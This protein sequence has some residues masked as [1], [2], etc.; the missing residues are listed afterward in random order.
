[1]SESGNLK[2]RIITILII[3]LIFNIPSLAKYSGGTGEL[4][5]PYQIAEPNDWIELMNTSVDWD[6]NFIMTADIDVNGI[7]LTP[8]GTY[9]DGSF[10]GIFDGNNCVIYNADINMPSSD[11]ARIKAI[12]CCKNANNRCCPC[13]AKIPVIFKH[14]CFN[15]NIIGMSFNSYSKVF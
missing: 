11:S 1:M 10:K 6:K 3:I 8:V 12:I 7:T 13:C 2:S 5:N 4:N 14:F 15:R 9:N